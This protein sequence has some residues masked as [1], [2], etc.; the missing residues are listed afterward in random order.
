M[1]LTSLSPCRPNLHSCPQPNR[2]R[3]PTANKVHHIETGPG[4]SPFAHFTVLGNE[5][6]GFEKRSNGEHT[7][8]ILHE[9]SANL[10]LGPCWPVCATTA[11]LQHDLNHESHAALAGI[12]LGSLDRLLLA[13]QMALLP[14]GTGPGP[15]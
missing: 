13:K 4:R 3:Q 12:A 6:R 8:Q 2:C 14:Y 10:T 9:W 15:I 7:W 5:E 11:A 1:I